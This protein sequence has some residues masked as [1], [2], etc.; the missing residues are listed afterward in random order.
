M[1]SR[2]LK[3]YLNIFVIYSV[4]LKGLKEKVVVFKL[5]LHNINV[6]SSE[7]VLIRN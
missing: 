2:L 4:S 7:F 6:I 3:L 5:F 1:K